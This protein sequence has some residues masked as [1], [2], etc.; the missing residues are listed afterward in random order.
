MGKRHEKDIPNEKTPEKIQILWFNLGDCVSLKMELDEHIFT[1]IWI[2]YENYVQA[3]FIKHAS[4]RLLAGCKPFWFENTGN[5]SHCT[6]KNRLVNQMLEPLRTFKM[7]LM[8]C[9]RFLDPWT[10]RLQHSIMI[11]VFMS[12]E[13]FRLQSFRCDC[14]VNVLSLMLFVFHGYY[15]PRLQWQNIFVYLHFRFCQPNGVNIVDLQG[16]ILIVVI[17]T[18]LKYTHSPKEIAN[19]EKKEKSNEYLTRGKNECG[20]TYS[21]TGWT[22]LYCARIGAIAHNG[23]SFKPNCTQ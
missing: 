18:M 22:L 21:A 13:K 23:N 9:T 15:F 8:H 19:S 6:N 14:S 7:C 4:M 2:Q 11:M 3:I 10:E 1:R 5:G 20:K 12:R 16:R 17:A